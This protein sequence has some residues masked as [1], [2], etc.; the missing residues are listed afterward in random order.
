MICDFKLE[1]TKIMPKTKLVFVFVIGLAMIGLSSGQVGTSVAATT[2]SHTS[3]APSTKKA[4]TVSRQAKFSQ[5][6][7]EIRKNVRKAPSMH[8]LASIYSDRLTGRRTSSGQR[9]CQQKMTAAHRSLPLGTKVLVTNLHNNKSVE[10]F[11]NDRGPCHRNRVIDLSSAA[12]AKLG[13]KK[14]GLV[15]VKLQILNKQSIGTS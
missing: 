4:G 6:T 3:H 1:S 9:F 2:A 12:A 14:R 10:V 13:M 11:I 15:Q 8:G 5:K 7:R